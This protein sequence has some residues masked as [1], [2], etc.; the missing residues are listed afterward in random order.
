MKKHHIL[1]LLSILFVIVCSHKLYADQT[2]F[3]D[4]GTV[5]AYEIKPN[6]KDK[7]LLSRDGSYA[8]PILR[9]VNITKPGTYF[10]TKVDTDGQI[11]ITKFTIQA[12]QHRSEWSVQSTKELPEILKYSLENYKKHITIQFNGGTY[13]IDEMNQMIYRML[14][15]LMEQYPK[16]SYVS[17]HMTSYGTVRPKVIIEFTYAL[18]NINLLKTYNKQ[19]DYKVI[20]LI[21]DLISPDMKD[22]E[23]EWAIAKY[24]ID[25]LMY[26]MR[27]T[28]LS[29]T[30][31]GALMEGMGVCDGY[32]KSMMYL[33]NSIGVPTRFVTGTANGGPHAWNL[34]KLGEGYYHVDLTWADA[35]E[36]HIGNFYNYLNETDTYMKLTH[37]WEEEK[38]P[39]AEAT[40]Y[41]STVAQLEQQGVYKVAS[42]EEWKKVSQL[43]GKDGLREAN[44]IFY[45]LEQNKWSLQAILERIM[46][47]EKRDMR[48]FTF[49][50]YDSL[51]VNYVVH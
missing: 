19:L 17:Y 22:Y 46:E 44:V 8:E 24:L 27:D 39:K 9:T 34:V 37:V 51:V 21:K 43:L 14:E 33:L 36:E 25:H 40:T 2:F 12:L 18:E 30:M 49:Y 45:N 28:D 5:K 6:N 7:L 29:H 32:T 38:Y 4:L 42:K 11:N 3:R 15:E 1:V 31:Q 26:A 13:T 50:K 10:L 47:S 35:D 20:E 41:L 16:L 23:R 48:Y